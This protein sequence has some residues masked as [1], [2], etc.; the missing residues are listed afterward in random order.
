MDVL[1]EEQIPLLRNEIETIIKALE[2]WNKNIINKGLNE[3]SEML[4]RFIEE[5]DVKTVDYE[6]MDRFEMNLENWGYKKIEIERILKKLQ[7]TT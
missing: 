7:I 2:F 6:L 4:Q 1:Q 5:A 3:A